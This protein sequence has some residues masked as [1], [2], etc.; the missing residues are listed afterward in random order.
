MIGLDTAKFQKDVN[1]EEVKERVAADQKR[2]AELGVRLTPT[3]LVMANP[4]PSCAEPKWN[5]RCHRRGA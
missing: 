2:A 3:I 5:T 1:G 4:L